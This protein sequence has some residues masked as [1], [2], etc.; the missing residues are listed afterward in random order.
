[1]DQDSIQG[2][3][4]RELTANLQAM[5]EEIVVGGVDLDPQWVGL[6]SWV[7]V[8]TE[9]ALTA[10]DEEW[11]SNACQSLGYD[12]CF[13]VITESNPFNFPC[14]RF[15]TT[16][17]GIF[18]VDS[19]CSA[20]HYVMFPEDQ[21]FAIL[22]PFGLYSL[23]GGPAGFVEL[24]VGSTIETAREMFWEFANDSNWPEAD[25]SFLTRLANKYRAMSCDIGA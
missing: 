12:Q 14:Y 25:R 3:T 19:Q 10:R 16:K 9:S 2:I 1:M 24:A 13:A 15:K 5:A 11:I 4:D 21:G 8:P 23:V 17:N 18:E 22:R 7:V 6:H 20:N